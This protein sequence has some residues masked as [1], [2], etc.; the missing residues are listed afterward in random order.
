MRI[1]SKESI[2]DQINAYYLDHINEKNEFERIHFDALFQVMVYKYDTTSSENMEESVEVHQ[3]RENAWYFG[4]SSSNE[5][6][7]S[8]TYSYT[9]VID[10]K[11]EPMPN[12]QYLSDMFH[13]LSHVSTI[14]IKQ[15]PSKKLAEFFTIFKP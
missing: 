10:L 15:A 2:F 8:S 13:S 3:F 7:S 1:P 5:S 6:L 11:T 4:S 9:F 12:G 14:F